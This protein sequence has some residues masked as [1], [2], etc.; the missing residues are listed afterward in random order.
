MTKPDLI[1]FNGQI[2]TQDERRSF[3]AAVAIKA[4]RFL[5][6]GTEPLEF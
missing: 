3:A 5:A 6:V 1:L 4:G 2:A